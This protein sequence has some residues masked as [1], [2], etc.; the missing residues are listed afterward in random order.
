[1]LPCAF[2]IIIIMAQLGRKLPNL[3]T[4]AEVNQYMCC[5]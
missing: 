4:L 1:M 2:W 5:G 3:A